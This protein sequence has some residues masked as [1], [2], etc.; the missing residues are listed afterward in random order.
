MK[1]K[2][3]PLPLPP[4]PRPLSRPTSPPKPSP[5]PSP[6]PSSTSRCCPSVPWPR[7]TSTGAGSARS[8]WPPGA[9]SA[10]P[11]A[12]RRRPRSLGSAPGWARTPPG[13]WGSGHSSCACSLGAWRRSCR[14]RSPLSLP[15][16]RLVLLLLLL[17]LQPLLLLLSAAR[18][19]AADPAA[20]ASWLLRSPSPASA[21]GSSTSS[22]P[23][24]YRR[25]SPGVSWALS[26]GYRA[27][28]RRVS[29]RSRSPRGS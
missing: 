16:R 23:R 8:S 21:C 19:E 6:W 20:R 14:L 26:T 25:G 24:T 17:L 22:P 13:R 28:S 10:P 12:S 7:P 18:A 29:G 2:Q 9:A 5:R 11:R 27:R 4:P 1:K 3:L 15:F